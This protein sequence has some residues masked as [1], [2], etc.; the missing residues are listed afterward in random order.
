MSI[1]IELENK[2]ELGLLQS[3]TNIFPTLFHDPNVKSLLHSDLDTISQSLPMIIEKIPFSISNYQDTIEQMRRYRDIQEQ[4]IHD[5]IQNFRPID[6]FHEVSKYNPE[7]GRA[8][9]ESDSICEALARIIKESN[10]RIQN[11]KKAYSLQDYDIQEGTSADMNSGIKQE[12]ET[13]DK[14]YGS[15]TDSLSFFDLGEL[16]R[17]HSDIGLDIEPVV[18]EQEYSDQKS[19][20]IVLYN[21]SG[22]YVLGFDKVE[23]LMD[24]GF[25]DDDLVSEYGRDI[26]KEIHVNHESHHNTYKFLNFN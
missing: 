7:I 13:E 22:R 23:N 18:G 25:V 11:F 12:Y 20:K 16:K 26:L 10:E 19:K 5:R 21:S 14:K 1:A 2:A 9:T 15:D 6:F 17:V 24:P 3:F 8:I 4:K